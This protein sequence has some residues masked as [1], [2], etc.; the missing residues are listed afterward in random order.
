MQFLNHLYLLIIAGVGWGGAGGALLPVV[1]GQEAG[2]GLVDRP[3][4]GNL[5]QLGSVNLAVTFLVWSERTQKEPTHANSIQK[6]A[7][8]GF[9]TSS[10]LLQGNNCTMVQPNFHILKLISAQL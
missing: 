8:V 2:Y 7:R 3:S 10:F 5:G 4:Q 9:K 1:F 6:E